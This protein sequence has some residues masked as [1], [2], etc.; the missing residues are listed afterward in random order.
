MSRSPSERFSLAW[1][2]KWLL[3]AY[4]LALVVGTHLP[5]AAIRVPIERTDKLL[6]FS[7]YAGLAFLLAIAWETSTGRLNGRH[8]RLLWMA[9]ALFAVLDEVTQLLVGRDATAGDWLADVLGAALGLVVF[10]VWQRWVGY[11]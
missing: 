11:T 5:P 9:I 2:W 7:A 10:R 1:L 4:A 6:H 3:A 8:L